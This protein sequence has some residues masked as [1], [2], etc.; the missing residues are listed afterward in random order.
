MISILLIPVFLLPRTVVFPFKVNSSENKA[1][2]WLGRGMSLYLSYG[3]RVNDIDTFSDNEG[4]GLLKSLNIKFPYN[5]SKASIIRAAKLMRAER[6]IW[7]EITKSPG[8]EE[9]TIS[10]RT[11][12]VD[13]K[14][15]KQRYLPVI[16]G[17]LTG[18][19]SV[20]KDLLGNLVLYTSGT[21]VTP[22]LPEMKFDLRNYELFIK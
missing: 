22:D 13:L 20:Q 3:L 18:L 4:R 11:F 6:L 2:Q 10:I 16:R 8:T 14:N 15:L 17:K 7:G 19:F 12:I 1:H 21:E 5:V 9:E